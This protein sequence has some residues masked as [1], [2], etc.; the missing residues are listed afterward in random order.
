MITSSS[1]FKLSPPIPP[2]PENYKKTTIKDLE[3]KD[4]ELKKI[5]NFSGKT[6]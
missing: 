6:A 5:N 2:M 1:S 3:K 4:K